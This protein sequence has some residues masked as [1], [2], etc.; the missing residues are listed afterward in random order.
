[1]SKKSRRDAHSP[2]RTESPEQPSTSNEKE[3][4]GEG[5]METVDVASDESPNTKE[6]GQESS[7]GE[8]KPK[9]KR[10][11]WRTVGIAAGSVI[12]L[13]ILC[14]GILTALLFT[15]SRPITVALGED[16]SL[17][18]LQTNPVLRWV[19]SVKTD[20][21]RLDTSRIGTH[22]VSLQFYGC[23]DRS[24]TV[25]VHD[26]KAPELETVDLDITCGIPISPSD[27]VLSCTDQTNVTYSIKE[28]LP[29]TGT[30]G[31]HT[32]TL[33]AADACGNRTESSVSLHI[34]EM[35]PSLQVEMMT[36]ISTVREMILKEHPDWTELTLD[37]SFDTTV[38]STYTVSARS[39]NTRYLLLAQVVDRVAPD[40]SL[41]DYD[42][43]YCRLN[44]LTV[45]DV[46][47][48][49]SDRTEVRTT[50]Q[51]AEP[52]A[53]GNCHV[54]VT[55]TDASGN[56]TQAT[57]CVKVY[58]FWDKATVERKINGDTYALFEALTEG[59]AE[60]S[61]QLS[62]KADVAWDKLP[63][64]E[65]TVY[66]IGDHNDIPIT[67]TIQD[68]CPPVVRAKAVTAYLG[69]APAPE[70]FIAACEDPSPVTYAFASQPDVSCA[71][72]QTV[73]VIATDEAGNETRVEAELTVR[74]DTVAPVFSGV[75]NLY[76]VLGDTLTY[77]TGVTATDNVDG[78]VKFSVDA[79][80]VKADT[81]GTYTVVYKATDSAGNTATKT[82]YV[83]ISPISAERLDQKADAILR[84]I[85][86]NSMTQRQK[87]EAIFEWCSSNIAYS[88]ADDQ[89][90]GNIIPAAYTGMTSHKGNC[91]TYYA[92]SATLLRRAGIQNMEICR[93]NPNQPHYWNLVKING[94]WYHFDACP[95]PS[96]H[97]LR[98]FL[99]TDAQ[100][101]AYSENEVKDYY[102]FAEGKYPAT[103]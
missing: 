14:T 12:G 100:V 48:S 83:T 84:A 43:L 75:K 40:L 80:A 31:D 27:F 65:N 36:Y 55:A 61:Y 64:G 97:Y 69:K 47:V 58:W 19:C 23:I 44:D 28:G 11:A 4:T 95:H 81:P 72:K 62:V 37:P 2:E 99:L 85:L 90:M 7:G 29:D 16:V 3:P 39:G 59:I 38:L 94:S 66:L 30:A 53:D 60:K 77:R 50:V 6:E 24:V 8:S 86:N 73:T 35:M 54:T 46:L 88:S 5:S 101:R 41:H 17:G 68:T 67:V 26:I 20:L 70:Q 15:L 103:P 63:L 76:F 21:A 56:E 18:A 93:D 102:R 71:G 13:A 89:Y 32:L 92:V 74:K 82:A 49:V 78:K 91:Y 1:M 98:C 9:R 87:A 52:D 42:T 33:I 34:G 22:E 45:Q 51:I 57:C 10:R 96:G 25:S 79:S